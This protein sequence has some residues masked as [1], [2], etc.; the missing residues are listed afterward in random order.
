VKA[1][2]DEALAAVSTTA[3]D[4]RVLVAD[5]GTELRTVTA[6]AQ[7]VAGDIQ[8]LVAGVREG[9]GSV[10]KLMNDDA[11]YEQLKGIAAEAERTLANLRAASEEAKSAISDFRG[12]KGPVRGVVGDLQQSLASARETLDD[13]SEAT[14]ALKRNF[15]FRGF[16]NRRGYFDL[17][18]VG[19]EEYRRGVVEGSDRR[20]LR[21]WVG[22]DVLFE[23]GPTGEERLTDDGR[24]RLDSAMAPFLR[25]PRDTPFV[26]EGYG[27]GATRAAEFLLSR[28]RAQLVRD[29]IVGKFGL[30]PRFV[31]TMAMGPEA[32]DSPAG[33]QWSGVALAA[34]VER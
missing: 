25:N 30:E 3:N 21:V 17:E 14:E 16:F 22:A 32:D 10:G 33:D 24:F 18:D 2:V 11:F 6:S 9:R 13:L 23:L 15:F 12:E 8:A 4:A 29:Y 7:R 5:I 27:A 28:T 31:A 34:F 20:V 19:V 1:G 26:V